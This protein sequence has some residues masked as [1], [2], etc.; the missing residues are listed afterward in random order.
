MPRS[1]EAWPDFGSYA[2]DVGDLTKD[3][4]RWLELQTDIEGRGRN[5]A[6]AREVG[7]DR[8]YVSR[9]LRG[10]RVGHLTLETLEQVAEAKRCEPWEVL[11]CVCHQ[12]A[13]PPPPPPKPPKSP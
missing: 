8:T 6:I 7:L 12:I 10:E 13:D 2:F 9:L 11:W 3:F 5:S 4:V 1:T